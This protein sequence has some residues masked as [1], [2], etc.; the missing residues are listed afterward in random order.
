MTRHHNPGWFPRA[1]TCECPCASVACRR[2][3]HPSNESNQLVY[4]AHHSPRTVEYNI[5]VCVLLQHSL[6]GRLVQHIKH[7]HCHPCIRSSWWWTMKTQQCKEYDKSNHSM[8]YADQ[9][10]DLSAKVKRTSPEGG[11]VFTNCYHRSRQSAY[12]SYRLC[13]IIAA[14]NNLMSCTNRTGEATFHSVQF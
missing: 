2:T 14:C 1:P 8:S 13:L 10:L 9:T 6:Y 7:F 3:R 11:S 5:N 4:L 12:G